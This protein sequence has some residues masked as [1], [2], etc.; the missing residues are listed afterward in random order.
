MELKKQDLVILNALFQNCRLSNKEISKLAKI[1]KE[2]TAAKIST[3]EKENII[4]GYGLKLDYDLLGFIEYN[5]FLRLKKV[6]KEN[7]DEL[8]KFLEG[9]KNV[10][11]IGKAFGKF[12]LKIAILVKDHN[13]IRNFQS[14]LYSKF[15]ESLDLLETLLLTD[16]YK[17]PT[18][19]IIKN[20]TKEDIPIKHIRKN[21]IKNT[22][23]IQIEK[24]DKQIMYE[25]GQNA[26]ER[27]TKIGYDLDVSSEVVKYRLE[28]LK[29]A[30]IVKGFG[31][32]I[33]GNKFEKVVCVILVN[34]NE[35]KMEDLKSFL[36][37][38]EFLTTYSQT[39][40]PY[41]FNFTLSVNSIV[42]LYEELNNIRS[43]YSQYIRDFDFQIF[44]DFFK[45]PKIPKCI[46]E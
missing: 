39:I 28:K 27:L 43:E 6:K 38:H 41:N 13:D 18:Q 17:A 16:K 32:I 36:K 25:L 15:G 14:K 20:L 44:F 4:R 12:D 7:F 24:L 10:T 11:W 2:T 3:L 29:K 30:G 40:G 33:D 22:L 1:T 8:I 19:T 31:V 34:V 45:Y 5:L 9:H 46:L 26:R 42:D 21:K 35:E 37:K 23:D